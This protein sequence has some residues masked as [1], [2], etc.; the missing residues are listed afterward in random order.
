MHR[1]FSAPIRMTFKV[2][3]VGLAFSYTPT[4]IETAVEKIPAQ[5]LL[6]ISLNKYSQCYFLLLQKK[7]TVSRVMSSYHFSTLCIWKSNLLLFLFRNFK[8][9]RNSTETWKK[10]VMLMHIKK[11]NNNKITSVR[12]KNFNINFNLVLNSAFI[13]FLHLLLIL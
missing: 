9:G 4:A 7:W 11:N 8:C 6:I 5:V 13:L 12:V 1:R 10:C 3:G 2:Q